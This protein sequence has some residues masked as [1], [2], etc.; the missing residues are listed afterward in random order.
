M[1]EPPRSP[2]IPIWL[3]QAGFT[4]HQYRVL[5]HLWSRGQGR[6]F[7]SMPTIAECCKVHIKTVKKAIRELEEMGFVTR[8]KRKAKG[9]RFANEYLLTGPNGAPVK[10]QQG[11]TDPLLTGPNGAPGNRA[12]SI[13]T[14]DTPLNDTSGNETSLFRSEIFS[15]PKSVTSK[16]R[17]QKELAESIYQ[18]YPKKK[19]KPDAIKAILKAMK[20]TAPQVLLERTRQYSAA[21]TWKESQFIPYPAT[22]FNKGGFDD[23]PASWAKPSTSKNSNKPTNA[24]DFKL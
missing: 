13:P 4:P 5:G 2:F 22:W 19:N 1:I 20:G 12:I 3:D 17:C 7:P 21:I 10:I 14:N 18:E 8:R 6:C 23:D 15:S 16:N 9:V 11:Q 24:N